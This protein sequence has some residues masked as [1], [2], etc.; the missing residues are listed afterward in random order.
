MAPNPEFARLG[1]TG[2]LRVAPIGTVAPTDMSAW[3]S[4]WVDLGY[5]SDDGITEGRDENQETFTP[6]QSNSPIRVETTSATE[7]F[8]ATLWESNFNV[9]S[10]YYRKG[11]SDMTATGGLVSFPVGGKPK[12][13]LRAFGVDVIDGVYK[14]RIVLPYAEVTERGDLVYQSSSLI[15]YECTIT[16]YEGSDGVSTLRMFDEGWTVPA[17]EVQ[18]VTITGTPTGGTFTLTYAGQTTAPIAYNATAT[19]VDSALE[20][21]SNIGPGDVTCTGGPL[22][23]TAVDITFTGLLSGQNVAQITATPSLTGGTT[24]AVNVTTVTPGG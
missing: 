23:G 21:L 24:P 18:R 12:R 6:W 14:R 11:A 3:P 17:S 15:G 16:A 8:Q 2:A 19:A 7:T 9:I 20:A 5:I 22:P 10:L 4:G 1:V 13:D